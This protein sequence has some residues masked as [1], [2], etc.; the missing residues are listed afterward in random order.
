MKTKIFICGLLT[1]LICSCHNNSK[2]WRIQDNGLYGLLTALA[3]KSLS[4]NTNM[5]V[6]SVLDM[7]A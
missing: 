7:L 3:M 2:L 4:P 1:L 5:L 6:T